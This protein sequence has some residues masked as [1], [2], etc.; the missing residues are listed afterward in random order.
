[1]VSS[2]EHSPQ[3]SPWCGWHLSYVLPFVA[4]PALLPLPTPPPSLPLSPASVPGSVLSRTLH[5]FLAVPLLH[6]FSSYLE[7]VGSHVFTSSPNCFYVFKSIHIFASHGDI[8]IFFFAFFFG[9][10]CGKW[11]FPGQ[12]SDH[13]SCCLCMP[14]PQPQPQ[15]HQ[16]LC[17]SL[18][19]CWI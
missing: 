3:A 8:Y 15:Q 11:K 13:S 10:T 2:V 16:T 17:H 7:A 19:Q 1:M 4:L 5:L 14:Q 18:R 9:H 6:G 12:G